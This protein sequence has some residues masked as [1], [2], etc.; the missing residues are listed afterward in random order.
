VE[1]TTKSLSGLLRKNPAQG[2][3]LLDM[4]LNGDLPI[5]QKGSAYRVVGYLSKVTSV[6]DFFLVWSEDE[7]VVWVG[8]TISVTPAS[9][10]SF[11][12]NYH[13]SGSSPSDSGEL[14]QHSSGTYTMGDEFTVSV[15][16]VVRV[17]GTGDDLADKLLA[18]SS[19]KDREFLS[20]L[21][22]GSEE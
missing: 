1:L 19:P 3:K 7:K 17:A 22:I 15:Y 11:D 14:T 12:L 20:S 21:G 5:S 13:L 4:V 10:N 2:E 16:K 18:K 8:K 6:G 9:G